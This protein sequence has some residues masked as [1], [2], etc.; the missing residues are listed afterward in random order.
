[1]RR[2]TPAT[3]CVPTQPVA[4]VLCRAALRQWCAIGNGRLGGTGSCAAARV[5]HSGARSVRPTA[6]RA[7]N[8]LS[9][10]E[11]ALRPALL[12]LGVL[13]IGPVASAARARVLRWQPYRR[14][15]LSA[16]ATAAWYPSRKPPSYPSSPE[17]PTASHRVAPARHTQ[18]SSV[19]L[20]AS[21][22][23]VGFAS[24]PRPAARARSTRPEA[25]H[26]TTYDLHHHTC[27]R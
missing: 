7:Q 4:A 14:C 5:L 3:V 19:R 17:K 23:H 18:R 25:G 12:V 16:P 10:R 21:R 6:P 8:A 26:T 9:Q 20:C 22:L 24:P 13:P 2:Q 1:M 11:P 15:G 27:Q